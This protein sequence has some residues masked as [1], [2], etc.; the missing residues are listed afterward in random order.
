ELRFSRNMFPFLTCQRSVIIKCIHV[1]IETEEHCG[2][3]IRIKYIPE[4][5][6][7]WCGDDDGC[8]EVM[9]RV[10]AKCCGGSEKDGGCCGERDGEEGWTKGCCEEKGKRCCSGTVFHGILEDVDIGPLEV[11]PRESVGRASVGRLRLPRDL[12]GVKEAY[13]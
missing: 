5:K 1:F 6:R 2:D 4:L 10:G 11:R 7:K 12:E 3:H 9:C 8:R 13:L